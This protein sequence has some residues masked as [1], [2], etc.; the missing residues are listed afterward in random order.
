MIVG[1]V[2]FAVGLSIGALWGRLTGYTH[3]L[4]TADEARRAEWKE[5]TD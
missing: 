5:N 1:S 4:R 3:G 2:A